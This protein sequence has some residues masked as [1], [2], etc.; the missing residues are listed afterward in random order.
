MSLLKNCLGTIPFRRELLFLFACSATAEAQQEVVAPLPTSI[1]AILQQAGIPQ[2]PAA[3]EPSS[4]S[5]VLPSDSP[6][7]WPPFVL[8]PHF[9]YRFLYEYGVQVRPGHPT[10][11]LIDTFA[12]G[13]S[14]EIGSHWTIDYT[15]NWD[16][17]SNHAFRDTLGHSVSVVGIN[18]Y[19][20]WTVQLTQGYVYSSQPLVET[21]LQ[22]TEQNY[23][24]ALDV[25]HDLGTHVLLETIMNQDL[26]YVVG[27][28]DTYQ[29][30]VDEWLHYRLSTQFDAAV[31]TSAGYVH[32]SRGSDSS[33]TRPDAELT[34]Q[35]TKKLEL[36][37][38]GGFEHRVYLD[39]PRTSL[40]T[41]TY[42]FSAQFDPV[43]T[44]KLTLEVV[45]QVTPTYFV[46]ET[47]KSASENLNLSQRLLGKFYL[48]G[49]VGHNEITYVSTG[50]TLGVAR[51]D[52]QTTY[53]L[54]LSTE[55]LRRGTFAVF[56][57]RTK[58]SSSLAGYSFATTQLGLEI[59]YKY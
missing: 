34:W 5:S 27:F 9:L 58:N 15:A 33:F 48:I 50:Q 6:F 14:L 49:G 16:I 36:K 10:T 24:T 39:Y 44:T 28:P 56:C 20:D 43:E 11:S 2:P 45:R 4:I 31:G 3:S 1:G 19:D 54:N 52:E 37:M 35:P 13:F 8:R 55:F 42:D 57:I 51:K 12:P 18:S 38:N 46:N 53:N 26:S 59:G 7:Q 29:W 32:E 23:K 22:T 30:S 47:T 25:S 17:Y 21:G 41:P 40:K